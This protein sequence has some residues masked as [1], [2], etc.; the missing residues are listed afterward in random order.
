MTITGTS[1]VLA[2]RL[3]RE[4]IQSGVQRAA[5]AFCRLHDHV[6]ALVGTAVHREH[7]RQPMTGSERANLA[8]FVPCEV[9]HAAIEDD[10]RGGERSCFGGGGSAG[11]RTVEGCFP[12]PE[13]RR[14]SAA[15]RSPGEAGS[16]ATERDKTHR[17]IDVAQRRGVEGF[18]ACGER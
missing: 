1:Q 11:I 13:D 16:E 8:I 17:S 12:P 4:L 5:D 2:V 18:R 15:R 3:R 6:F 9:I 14:W 10:S 7:K